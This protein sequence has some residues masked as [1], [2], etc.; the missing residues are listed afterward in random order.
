[1]PWRISSITGVGP[2]HQVR[3]DERVEL[4]SRSKGM[5]LY[6]LA[7]SL[8]SSR[9]NDRRRHF[10]EEQIVELS[11][12]AAFCVRFGRLGA[13]WNMIEELPDPI[14]DRRAGHALGR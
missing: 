12:Y 11:T 13:T 10:S 2:V 8:D 14:Q 6:L 5:H 3:A 1:L 7:P 9:I 4:P